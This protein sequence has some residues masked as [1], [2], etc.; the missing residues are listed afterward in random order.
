MMYITYFSDQTMLRQGA[1][2]RALRQAVAFNRAQSNAVYCLAP[3][4]DF[5]LTR[6]QRLPHKGPA[7]AYVTYR[8]SLATGPA[9]RSEHQEPAAALA[10]S[11]TRGLKQ[12]R[13][14]L[15]QSQDRDYLMGQQLA[16]Y[17]ELVASHG[18]TP[19]GQP[20]ALTP[21]QWPL[22]LAEITRDLAG[23]AA[24]QRGALPGS[25][26]VAT[27]KLGKKAAVKSRND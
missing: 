4:A 22:S 18:P 12:P 27:P 7:G 10:P 23:W 25:Q 8:L 6:L 24:P 11:S 14:A 26:P 13:L 5:G 16:I 15:V 9:S 2:S 20:A 17:E 19:E 3:M 1:A 21:N